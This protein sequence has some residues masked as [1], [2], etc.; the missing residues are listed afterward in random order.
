MTTEGF[1]PAPTDVQATW[2]SGTSARILVVDDQPANIQILGG[3]LGKLGCEIVPASDG[4]TALKRLALRVPDLILLDVLMPGM[5]GVEVCRRI[6]AE[7]D[8]ADIPIIFL[9][10]ADDKELIIRA[11]KAGGVD[12]V[13]KP[14]N[15]A[16]MVLRVR[17]HLALKAARDQLKQLA[18]DKDELI[19][20]LAHDMKNHLGGMD[21][22]ARLLRERMSR[23]GDGKLEQLCENICQS[24]GQLLNFV[25]EFLANSAAEHGLTYN[26][27]PVNLNEAATRAGQD[28]QDA[29]RRKMLQLDLVLP[30]EPVMVSADRTALG[31]VLDN[32]LSNAVKFSPP[33]K[34]ITLSVQTADGSAESLVQDQGPGFSEEDKPRMFRR[35]GRLSARPT[36]GEPSTG[37]G[38]SIVKK[39][40]QNMG[41]ELT[42]D[43]VPGEGTT[44]RVRLPRS[45]NPK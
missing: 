37:L 4:P 18:E 14:F 2:P 31:Q 43:S 34:K 24:S 29:A 13:T 41:G 30:K 20:I 17:T 5:D 32:L 21:M 44:F 3:M 16:E 28:Y 38:L 1:L 12:Y 45:N 40:V 39:L 33:G 26:L 36:G 8:W 22:S 10:A 42:C 19:G 7:P 27:Q 15:H 6:Q 11:L 35:Y 9:S 25:K 23:L